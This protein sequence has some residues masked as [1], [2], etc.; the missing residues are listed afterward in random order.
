MLLQSLACPSSLSWKSHGPCK[1]DRVGIVICYAGLRTCRNK[2]PAFGGGWCVILLGLA[3]TGC[4][5]RFAWA[6]GQRGPGR[7][8]RRRKVPIPQ[9]NPYKT[10]ELQADAG[11]TEV[12]AAFRRL[13]K[14]YH[15]DVPGTGDALKFQD[16]L[17]ASEQLATEEQREK[18]RR[19]APQPSM[20]GQ[21]TPA[22]PAPQATGWKPQTGVSTDFVTEWQR[23]SKQ[24]RLRRL[25]RALR[26]PRKKPPQ[27]FSPGE[28]STASLTRIQDIMAESMCY[29][30]HL[31]TPETSLAELGFYMDCLDED[32]AD[33][34][35]AIEDAFDIDLLVILTG[36]WV[37]FELPNSVTSVADFACY[38]EGLA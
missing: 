30:R 8:G 21:T 24:R 19:S 33:C 3:L 7:Y 35:M 10:L 17:R 18:W 32:V 37:K 31:V 34:V 36:G 25:Q 16:L 26:N 20:A 9:T 13:A 5:T 2:K 27:S 4:T 1:D 23:R 28:P 15:P 12:R 14:V 38:V 22:Y 11:E 6:G 29:P